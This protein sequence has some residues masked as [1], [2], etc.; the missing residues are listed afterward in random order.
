MSSK[1]PG[2]AI[3][4]VCCAGSI[5]CVSGTYQRVYSPPPAPPQIAAA[6]QP[7]A[8]D[9]PF[10]DE[11][12]PYGQWVYTSG[13]GW[14]WSPYN[15]SAGWRPYQLGHWVLTDYGWTWASDEDFGWAVY[16]YGRWTDDPQYGWVWVPGTE[17]GPAWVAW[18]EGN[19]W[20]G[21]APLPWQVSWQ[22]GVGLDWGGLNINVALGPS[23]WYFVPARA[24]VDPGLR[25][26]IA[27]TSQNVTL[28]Q[29]TTNVTNYTYIDNR[30]VNQSVQEERIGRAVG[31]TIP[32]YHLEQSDTPERAHGGKV[33]GDRFVV[34]R[35]DPGRVAN[36]Q[37]RPVP[38]GHDEMNPPP[39]HRPGDFHGGNPHWRD[40][41]QPA[42]DQPPSQQPPETRG[43]GPKPE[44]AVAPTA[45]QPPQPP[46]AQ[47]P[48]QARK[49]D[50][51]S[52]HF[53]KVMGQANK[54]MPPGH[55]PPQVPATQN[56]PSQNPQNQGSSSQS[57][58]AQ[59]PPGRPGASGQNAP[60]AAAHPDV[61]HPG[62][63]PPAPPASGQAPANAPSANTPPAKPNQGGTPPGKA[64]GHGPADADAKHGKPKPAP[65]PPAPPSG[66]ADQG[67]SKPSSN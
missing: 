37:R 47:Q 6:P 52:S 49:P 15:V 29:K 60:P 8:E 25:S 50:P 22:A 54:W 40:N 64:K 38:P 67:S 58:P 65:A 28:I 56:P 59:N 30:I 3:I 7:G 9:Q 51:H 27:P 41:Q 12:S 26:Y 13:P 55:Q 21:W 44:P 23:S 48:P 32:R 45:P 17:W 24:M 63:T 43:E 61:A 18:H 11:L 19:G 34:Y 62:V 46:Q 36:P 33:Q 2:I 10:H 16:H 4:I 20:V 42:N 57:Q 1:L 14:V 31:H 39:G 35:P 53:F 66:T 5:A